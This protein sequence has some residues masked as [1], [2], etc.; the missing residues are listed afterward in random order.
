MC[1]FEI[2]KIQN[3]H[4]YFFFVFIKVF[5]RIVVAIRDQVHDNETI[6]QLRYEI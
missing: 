1:P 6:F 4:L 3:H 2:K 5:F